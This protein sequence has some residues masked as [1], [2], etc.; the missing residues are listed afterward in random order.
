MCHGYEYS[1]AENNSGVSPVYEVHATSEK[2]VDAILLSFTERI[3]ADEFLSLLGRSQG[4]MSDG[5]VQ[6][7][8]EHFE[9][10]R[11]EVTKW[12]DVFGLKRCGVSILHTDEGK[13]GSEKVWL[14][15]DRRSF[16][17]SICM[18]KAWDYPI[19]SPLTE[20]NIKIFAFRGVCELLF[21]PMDVALAGA[22]DGD[23]DEFY[24]ARHAVIGVLENVI[25][26][27]AM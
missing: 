7:T 11:E 15:I 18:A 25:W 21:S 19:A 3:E 5:K 1:I 8:K 2:G 17:A 10:F 16:V 9:I 23:L 20:D 14:S 24:V 6:S 13:P 4:N 27:G 22:R 12:L 26:K